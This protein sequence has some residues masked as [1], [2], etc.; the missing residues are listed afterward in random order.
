M[1]V[2][3][4]VSCRSVGQFSDISGAGTGKY[5][6]WAFTGSAATASARGLRLYHGVLL[7]FKNVFLLG[8][9]H[10]DC[11]LSDETKKDQLIPQGHMF[12][13]SRQAVQLN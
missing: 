1:S 5:Q 4:Q 12:R 10:Y 9:S 2:A 8:S 3:G 13:L 7:E 11:P 6:A